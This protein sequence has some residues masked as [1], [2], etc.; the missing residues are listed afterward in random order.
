MKRLRATA[1][2]RLTL[3]IAA[4]WS[5]CLGACSMIGL[6]PSTAAG[7]HPSAANPVELTV[8][9]AASL[10]QALEAVKTAYAATEPGVGLTIATDSSATLRTQIEQGAPAD[11]FLSAD[12]KNPRT[13]AAAGLSD[14]PAVDFAGNR[15]TI[16]V[17]ADN[18]AGVHSPLDLSRPRLRVVAAGVDVPISSYADQ[19]VAKLGTL[20]GHDPK[21]FASAYAANVV[22]REQNVQAVVAKIELGEGDAAIVY[23]TDARAATGLATIAIPDAANVPATYAGVVIAASSR[24][25]Q[26]HRFLAW[27][28]GPAGR[29]VLA[30]FGFLPPP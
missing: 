27:L 29:A 22:S 4:A 12:Q 10:K 21:Q 7:G 2:A 13:L 11:V 17:P 18:P 23:E 19:V 1:R 25:D 26:A 5:T 9:G 14:G 8:F 6:E 16:I 3:T 30:K 28:A 15:L 24:R 20:A